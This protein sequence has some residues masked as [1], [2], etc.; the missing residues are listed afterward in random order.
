MKSTKRKYIRIA[1]LLIVATSLQAQEIIF[2]TNNYIEYQVGNLPLVIAVSHGG[3][4]EP[5]SIP[6]RTCNNPV[7][8]TDLFTIETALEI[9]KKLLE[10]TGCYPHIIIAHLKRS[11]LDPNR[12]VSDGACGHPEAITAWNEFHNFIN[13]AQETAN[14]AFNNQTFFIDL[15]GH[16]NPIQRIELGYLLYDDELELSDNTLNT[17][18][19]IN[20]SS[21]RNLALS[22]AGNSTHAQLLRGPAAF[23]TLLS[24]N[25][26]PA[27]PS[28]SIPFPG[29][30]S[31]YFS[32]GYI[33]A[34]HTSYNPEVAM[35]GL[36]MELNYAPIR[37]TPANRTAF[38]QAFTNSIMAYFN[39]HFT[40]NWNACNPTQTSG[41]ERNTL[42]PVYPNPAT[43]GS[44]IQ[45]GRVDHS[46]YQYQ[47]LDLLGQ[48][49]TR[50]KLYSDSLLDT[51]P[52]NS[53]VY[54]ILISNKHN[55][56]LRAHK[57]IIM[58]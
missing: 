51:Q 22:N 29:L 18:Q 20:Y 4:L 56:T 10:L 39:T 32:G 11:K 53:G 41:N 16:G 9:K 26:Y 21:I 36:Q 25:N 7:F 31:N 8:A 15:H 52:L 45:L 19:Y 42:G 27:V 3:S 30:Q 47:V 5:A 46:E 35:N 2:G 24:N 40:V 58:E 17:N 34:N 55:T 14:Q 6:N 28:Q 13:L 23:G 12:N 44:L 37:D 48:L 50:G 54:L 57:L 1:L 43:R 49:I 33:T 38:A